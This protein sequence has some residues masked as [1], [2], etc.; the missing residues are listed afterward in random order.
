M[1]AIIERW[2]DCN[3]KNSCPPDIAWK[4]YELGM[5]WSGTAFFS[6]AHPAIFLWEAEEWLRKK[7]RIHII[8][9]PFVRDTKFIVWVKIWPPN[10]SP[11]RIFQLKTILGTYEEAKILGI[12]RAIKYLE[13]E[14]IQKY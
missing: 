9:F 10:N 8:I 7:Y 1:D 5:D 6:N 14:V 2:F 3:D 12:E 4:L 11:E 13:D